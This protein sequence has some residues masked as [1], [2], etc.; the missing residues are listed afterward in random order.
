MK[1]RVGIGLCL[2]VGLAAC[3][4][5]MGEFNDAREKWREA[6][7]ATYTFDL[8]EYDYL[9]PPPTHITVE[10]GDVTAIAAIRPNRVAGRTLSNAPTIEVLF[11]KI[12]EELRSDDEVT[13]TWDPTLGFPM[14]VNFDDGYDNFG[15][16]V[17][18]FQPAP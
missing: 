18:T 11:D 5:G 8:Y 17:A 1:L 2:L 4:D 15:F 16:Q 9:A 10:N 6:A 12:E 7:I 3:D 13:V 14:L